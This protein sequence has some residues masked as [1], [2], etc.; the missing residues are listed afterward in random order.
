VVY[1]IPGDCSS[2]PVSWTPRYTADTGNPKLKPTTADQLDFTYEWYFSSS[3]SFTAAVFYKKF[4]DYIVK[5]SEDE[6]LTNNGVT[7]TVNVTR[8]V[9]ADGAKVAGF[10][11]AYQTFFDRLPSPWN[12]FGIQANFTFVDNKGVENSGLTI[13][14]GGGTVTQDAN[15]SFTHLPLEGFSDKAY[16]LV[17]M[18]EKEKFSG[19]LAY[20]WRDEFL[21]TQADCCVK[22]PIWQEAYGQLDASF[23][24]KPSA[25][26]DIFLDIQNLTEEETVLRQQ[27]NDQGL[28]L[29]RSWF[30]NDMRLQ[31]GVR[32]RIQ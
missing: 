25:D 24:Y 22:L 5:A 18:Y 19:R 1:S 29:P 31:L 12:G 11:V 9:N 4:N 32:F 30:T 13:V 8:P 15:I 14:S 23:R 20:N 16:N 28:T 3:G 2:P 17:L 6:Q 10:E 26:W 27:V 7:R 21:Q